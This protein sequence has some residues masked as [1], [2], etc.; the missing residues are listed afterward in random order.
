MSVTRLVLLGLTLSA[1]VLSVSAAG[2]ERS[3]SSA[4]EA[5]VSTDSAFRDEAD[6]ALTEWALGR[7]VGAGLDL[8]RISL[9]FHDEKEP[10]QGQNG[11]FHPGDPYRIDIC[12]FNWDRFLMTP[13]KVILHEM[14]HVWAH[15]NLDAGTRQ[16]FIEMRDLEIWE[17][18]SAP[19]A[20][21]GQEHAA[22][23]LAWAL[24]DEEISTNSIGGS[25]L[26]ELAAAYS[27]LISS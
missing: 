13:R 11:Y 22:E 16:E 17:D 4:W 8:P 9:A 18:R 7:F 27:F 6:I 21:Q 26:E 14:G 10:C 23:I 25:R 15:E 24:M 3:S 20:E 2:G 5:V 12:G 1:A 19:W